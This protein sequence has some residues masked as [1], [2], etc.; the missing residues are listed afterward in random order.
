VNYVGIDGCKL[1]WFYVQIN[2]DRSYQ[3]GVVTSIREI[4]KFITPD[5]IV[6]LD[7]PIGLR[8]SGSQ[9][10]L[11]DKEARR[12]LS[13]KRSSSVFPAPCRPALAED[14]YSAGSK[15]NFERTGR[16]LSQQS[17]AIS[18]KIREVDAF[19]T[20]MGSSLNIRE[21]HPE[22]CFW[23]FNNNSPLDFAKKKKAG[24]EERMEL[25]RSYYEESD[26]VV[27]QAVGRYLRKDVAR[28]DILDALV[29][30][31]TA[32]YPL[33]SVPY[34]REYDEKG[35]PMEIVYAKL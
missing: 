29:G 22:V 13:P 9:E 21:M 6:L 31:V 30:A 32:M 24:F 7:I 1:G 26:T 35:L 15:V 18:M 20:E 4:S 12:L 16:K 23:S 5:D 10:R 2:S 11:C 28:D 27:D 8:E 25:V 17:W 19:M 3:L 14:S 34:S 33:M